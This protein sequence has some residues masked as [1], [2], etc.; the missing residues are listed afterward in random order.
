MYSRCCAL[1]SA[2]IS[3]VAVGELFAETASSEIQLAAHIDWTGRASHSVTRDGTLLNEY[4]AHTQSVY[5]EGAVLSV[6]MIPRFS[7]APIASITVNDTSVTTKAMKIQFVVNV[8]GQTVEYPTIVDRDGVNVRFTLSSVEQ[9]QDTFRDMLDV[10]SSAAFTWFIESDAPKLSN[11]DSN[12]TPLEA[13][14]N[15]DF[16]LLGSKRTVEVMEQLCRQHK[17]IPLVN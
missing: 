1:I 10:S 12:F 2:C 5:P 11:D 3:I 16:S 17:P 7:C 15:F 13:S 14:G 8:D 6:T 4:I 9:A